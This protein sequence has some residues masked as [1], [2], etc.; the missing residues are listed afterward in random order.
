ML[1]LAFIAISLRVNEEN[2]LFE[3]VQSLILIIFTAL[4]G[5]S[6]YIIYSAE[7]TE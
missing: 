4:K 6:F 7:A 1:S 2:S 3:T 5:T